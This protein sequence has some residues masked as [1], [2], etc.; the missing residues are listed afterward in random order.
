M[1]SNSVKSV[2]HVRVCM[3]VCVS[4]CVFR[5]INSQM[6][7]HDCVTTVW[8]DYANVMASHRKKENLCI[9]E[10]EI[11][12]NGIPARHCFHIAT[13]SGCGNEAICF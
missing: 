10:I 13:P 11:Q 6:I 4:V 5:K 12:C 8:K 3:S 1:L 2:V 9:Q 7:K